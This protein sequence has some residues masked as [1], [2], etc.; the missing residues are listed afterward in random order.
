MTRT[1][2]TPETKVRTTLVTLVATV[3]SLVLLAP[4]AS[5]S[6]AARDGTPRPV[7]PDTIQLPDGFAPEGIAAGHG[8]TFFAGSL[9]GGDIYRGNLRTG[10]GEVIV[11]PRDGQVAVGMKVDRRNRLWAAGGEGGTARVY[12]ARSGELIRAFELAPSTPTFVNDVVVTP[13]AA[14][15]TDSMRHALYRV[16]IGPGGSLGSPEEVPLDEEVPSVDGFNLNGI[17]ATR[18][19][20]T[21]IVAHSAR[22]ELYTIDAATAEA[23]KVDLGGATLPNADGILLTGRTLHVVQNSDNQIAE[24]ALAPD[25]SSGTVTRTLTD[26]DF[27]VPTTIARFGHALYAVNARFGTPVEPGTEYSVVRVG[28]HK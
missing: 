28:L 22:G 23:E 26:P 10:E 18:D 7:F 11:P 8:T 1:T 12:D 21:L 20:K 27:D 17:D 9:N 25:L 24:V 14:W 13:Q 19:G 15:F 2:R 6:S 3:A 4:A 16:P 5:A